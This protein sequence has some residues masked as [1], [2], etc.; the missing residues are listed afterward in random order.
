MLNTDKSFT[1]SIENNIIY[2]FKKI[3]Y[4]KFIYLNII[5]KTYNYI[6]NIVNKQNKIGIDRDV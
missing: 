6:T 4:L 2:T 5:N 1:F 3:I